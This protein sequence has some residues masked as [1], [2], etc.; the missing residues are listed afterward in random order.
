MLP[1]AGNLVRLAARRVNA[2][3]I[4]S[5]APLR[6]GPEGPDPNAVRDLRCVLRF[7]VR[8]HRVACGGGGASR[9]AVPG[10]GVVR[11]W[12]RRGRLI[13]L[14]ARSLMLSR[15]RAH[16]NVLTPHANGLSRHRAISRNSRSGS[17]PCGQCCERTSTSSLASSA[18]GLSPS[19]RPSGTS[20]KTTSKSGSR[21]SRAMQGSSFKCERPWGR[22]TPPLPTPTHVAQS[23]QSDRFPG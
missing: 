2:P 20:R 7:A 15:P 13:L 5:K 9:Q 17:K 6:G 1:R 18:S 23:H 19:N 22:S 21:A 12:E 16:P 10:P 14:H 11:I 8:V 3:A 4:R